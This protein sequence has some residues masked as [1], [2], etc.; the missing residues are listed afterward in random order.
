VKPLFVVLGTFA[1]LMIVGY[2][3]LITFD[4]WAWWD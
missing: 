3:L 1:A 4:N 2:V